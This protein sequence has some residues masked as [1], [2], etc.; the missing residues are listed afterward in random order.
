MFPTVLD[1]INCTSTP[2]ITQTVFW[3]TNLVQAILWRPIEAAIIE[4]KALVRGVPGSVQGGVSAQVDS[5]RGG[6]NEDFSSAVLNLY[7]EYMGATVDVA[8]LEV[9]GGR[10]ALR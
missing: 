5:D 6:G 3:R 1:V 8:E 2:K 10:F 7:G 9:A 4:T